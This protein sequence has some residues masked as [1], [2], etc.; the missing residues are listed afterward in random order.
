MQA[1]ELT[2]SSGAN[3]HI[4][5]LL[6]TRHLAGYFLTIRHTS[7]LVFPS[8]PARRNRGRII[9]SRQSRVEGTILHLRQ[10]LSLHIAL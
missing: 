9:S 1:N 6:A 7:L 10:S 4:N 3:P 5:A 2:A 8:Q